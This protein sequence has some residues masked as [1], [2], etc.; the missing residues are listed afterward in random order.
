MY[1]VPTEH[2]GAI[3][4]TNSDY[5]WDGIWETYLLIWAFSRDKDQDGVI[6]GLDNCLDIANQGQGDAD[7]D[8]VGDA[9]D[10]C[11]TA[12]NVGQADGDADGVGDLC[13]DCMDID[14]DGFGDPGFPGNIC[15]TD[16][17]PSIVNPTQADANNDGIGDACCC[18]G[19]RGNV[20]ES[21][22]ESPDLSDVS[23]LISYL[24]ISPRPTLPCPEEAN[25]NGVGSID[26]SD[27]SL[28][29]AYLTQDPR[30]TLPNCQ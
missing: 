24:T 5:D 26:L 27:M 2:T 17:C 22:S 10:N 9:C 13:D 18:I 16:N 8:G 12:A 28:C 1:G 29:I 15:E 3:M 25:M 14:H 30:P 23:L 21:V 11:P 7:Q 19:V 20:N 6:A 4:L